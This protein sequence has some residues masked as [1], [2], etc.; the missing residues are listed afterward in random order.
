M[1]PEKSSIL[2][3]KYNHVRLYDNHYT[4]P[5]EIAFFRYNIHNCREVSF[6]LRRITEE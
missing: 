2:W 5:T 4:S 1:F 3:R 6:I